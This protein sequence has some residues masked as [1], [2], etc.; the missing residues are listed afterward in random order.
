M[1]NTKKAG[2]VFE[3][4]IPRF[5]AH[6]IGSRDR[7]NEHVKNATEK[8]QTQNAAIAPAALRVELLRK[9]LDDSIVDIVKEDEFEEEVKKNPPKSNSKEIENNVQFLEKR[10]T[11]NLDSTSKINNNSNAKRRKGLSFEVDDEQ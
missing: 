6:Q 11:S 8:L 7:R 4:R 2:F 9:F 1:S 10:S 5:L 3:Q